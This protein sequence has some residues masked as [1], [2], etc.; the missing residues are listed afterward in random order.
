VVGTNA[1]PVSAANVVIYMSRDGGNTWVDS[2]GTFPNNG[3]AVVTLPNPATTVSTARIK[4]KGAGNV[5]FNVNTNNF[6]VTHSSASHAGV[7]AVTTIAD[8]VKVYPNP[9]SEELHISTGGG[10]L[11]VAIYNT[12]GQLVYSGVS[13]SVADIQVA[14][15]ARGVYFVHCTDAASGGHCVKSVAIQ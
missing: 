10:L 2:L 7:G 9:A 6:T 3:S 11:N 14:G 1:A 15:W 12:L 4:V 5:F 13:G 8:A